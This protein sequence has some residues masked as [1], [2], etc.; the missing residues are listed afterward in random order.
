MSKASERI[1]Q[2]KTEQVGQTGKKVLLVEGTDDV[3][4][5]TIFLDRLHPGWEVSWLVVPAGKKS[6]VIEMVK[7]EPKWI[8]LVDRD[9]WGSD[10][11]D[12][13]DRH[14]PNLMFL[15]RFCLESYLVD[16]EELWEAFPEKQ[17]VKIPGGV[18]QLREEIF[19]DKSAWIRHAALWFEVRSIWRQLRRLGFPDE[20]MNVPEVPTDDELRET[21]SI[22]GNAA[23]PLLRRIHSLE[24][25]LKAEDETKFCISWLYAKDFYPVVVHRVLDRL[26]GQMSAKDRRIAILRKRKLPDDLGF[27]WA[28]MELQKP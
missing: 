9:E 4:A 11:I 12:E 13:L 15:P 6:A 8:G 14:H 23:E 27:L 5:Y 26:L 24:A 21:F 16:P 22:W 28:A 2:I 7:L 17:R 19:K 3:T 20:V 25:K 10:E 18:D 1:E